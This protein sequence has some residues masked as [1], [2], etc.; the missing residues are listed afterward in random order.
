MEL[1]TYD[2]E[3]NVLKILD[4][5]DSLIWTDRYSSA[6]DFEILTKVTKSYVSAL[7]EDYFLTLDGSEH[8]MIVESLSLK[9]NETDG[10]T[11]MVRGRSLESILERRIVWKQTTLSG[12][13][14]DAIKTL[15]YENAIE[16]EDPDRKI[17][18]LVFDESVDPYI[19]GLSIDAQYT[20]EDLYSIITGLCDYYQIG[21]KIT[22]SVDK[23][24]VFALYSGTNRSFDQIINPFVAFSPKLD[25]LTNTNYFHSKVPYRTITLVAGEG[26]GAD[27]ITTQVSL[28]GG[29]LTD[30]ARRE[31]FT[32][33]SSVSTIIDGYT[34]TEEEYNTLLTQKG[35]LSL[36][37]S[38][39]ISSFD[40]LIDA[41]TTYVYGEDFFLG[42]IVQIENEY[43][44]T[45]RSRITELVF[46]EDLSGRGI[47]PTFEMME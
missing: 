5:F 40:G 7:S 6:G 32:D 25:N 37:E 15:L 16:P 18:R 44:L 39:P 23:K 36:L 22:L 17:E 41:T 8:A 43:G 10:D 4:T 9:T 3:L 38:Q 29:A 14:Q 31:K 24:F 2:T 20:G 13:L 30:L 46:S 26:E 28:P 42:D 47:Y 34:L 12:G 27:R 21:F 33:A 45:G 35:L 19:L 1:R 11:F